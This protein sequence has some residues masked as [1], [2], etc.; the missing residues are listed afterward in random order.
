MV[1]GVCPRAVKAAIGGSAAEYNAFRSWANDVKGATGDA[2]AGE[3]AA[4]ANTHAAA[5][6]ALGAERLFENEPTIEI[7]DVAVATGEGGGEGGQGVARP[8]SGARRRGVV[9]TS[10]D[11]RD[12]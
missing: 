4:V 1:C 3:A 10:A 5:A 11:T 2:V 6:Y 8:T 12:A 7:E 9:A